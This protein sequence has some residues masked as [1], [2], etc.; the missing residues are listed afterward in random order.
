MPVI[1]ATKEEVQEYFE[2]DA[3]GQSKLKLLLVDLSSFNKP[4]M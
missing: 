3:L 4:F 1:I 2:S